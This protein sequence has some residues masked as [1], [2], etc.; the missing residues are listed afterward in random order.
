MTNPTSQEL[1]KGLF[2][3]IK[4]AK[5]GGDS[6]WERPGSYITRI[7]RVRLDKTRKGETG[8]YIEKTV[9]HVLEDTEGRPHRVGE[10]I[11]HALWVKHDS[12]LGNVK[13]FLAGVLEMNA[14]D[15]VEDDVLLVIAD[16]QPL[17]GT[18]IETSNR[19][20]R[21]LADNPFTKISYKG[22]VLASKLKTLLPQSVQDRFFPDGMLDKLQKIEE[23]G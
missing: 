9:L 19:T 21:T 6:D 2:G 16:D 7:D 14:A 15:I 8:F 18:V 1:A 23:E 13:S 20:I 10:A 5:V 11:T 4:D 22:P 12:F 3:G 17:A